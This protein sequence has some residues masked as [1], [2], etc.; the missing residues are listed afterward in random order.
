M[1]T[2]LKIKW[3]LIIAIL[4]GILT[5]TSWSIWETG[6]QDWRVLVITLINTIALIV[7]IISYSQIKAFR[8]EVYRLW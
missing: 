4:L 8:K 1:K 5:I 7:W 6:S 3:E 2:I